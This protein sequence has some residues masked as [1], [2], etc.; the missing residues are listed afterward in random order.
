MH[1]ADTAC[2]VF[3]CVAANHLGLVD[4]LERTLKLRLPVVNC[5]K[6]ATFWATL[7][8][9]LL[10]CRTGWI[11][12]LAVSLLLAYAALWLELGMGIVDYYYS[13]IYDKIISTPFK[14]T[15]SACADDGHAASSVSDLRRD[16]TRGGQPH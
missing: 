5:P 15:P 1:W 11:T 4:A 9:T 13:R 7:A 8:H 14:D 16:Q 6:C 10:C 3:A 12:S 2:I